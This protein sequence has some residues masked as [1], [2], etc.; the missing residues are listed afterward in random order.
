[1]SQ[2][3]PDAATCQLSGC[4][5]RALPSSS[6]CSLMHS[7]EAVQQGEAAACIYC[8]KFAQTPGSLTCSTVCGA[9]LANRPEQ[10][11]PPPN[12]RSRPRTDP[13]N[14]RRENHVTYYPCG[15]AVVTHSASPSATCP[16]CRPNPGTESPAQID[17]NDRPKPAA[18]TTTA[19]S[20]TNSGSEPVRTK[21]S[22]R[23]SFKPVRISSTCGCLFR[24]TELPVMCPTCGDGVIDAVSGGDGSGSSLSN[25]GSKERP[26]SQSSSVLTGREQQDDDS[27][28]LSVYFG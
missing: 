21:P 28:T 27:R 7:N 1:M 16:I 26:V 4:G 6:Y 2:Q 3:Q 11:Q 25:H 8:R 20:S 12:P 10:G 9:L 19:S 5:S 23:K 17:V 14:A 24:V 15:C 18:A 13:P 22:R